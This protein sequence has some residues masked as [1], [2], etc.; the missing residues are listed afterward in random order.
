MENIKI[1]FFPYVYLLRIYCLLL[2]LHFSLFYSLVHTYS[3]NILNIIDKYKAKS[4]N[5]L[6]S[7]PSSD[8]GEYPFKLQPHWHIF[9]FYINGFTLHVVLKKT[10][11][12]SLNTVMEIFHDSALR[13]TSFF[14]MVVLYFFM[15][16][17][18]FSQ[19]LN[20][21]YLRCFQHFINKNNAATNVD[22]LSKQMQLLY[23]LA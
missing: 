13:A 5:F 9:V 17:C 19:F 4:I 15:Y 21:G 23:L 3:K 11:F 8:I 14:L 6:S 20:D 2:G 22:S 10:W 18:L 7:T 12:F 1:H 16:Q